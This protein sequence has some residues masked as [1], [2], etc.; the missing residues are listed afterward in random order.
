MSLSTAPSNARR[1]WALS[2][3]QMPVTI[4]YTLLLMI[5]WLYAIGFGSWYGF[6]DE[7]GHENSCYRR[8]RVHR[9]GSRTHSPGKWAFRHSS[10]QVSRWRHAIGPVLPIYRICAGLWRCARCTFARRA[11]AEGRLRDSAG[12]AGWRPDMQAGSDRR[13]DDEP[14]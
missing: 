14:R 11:C 3:V 6:A 9:F 8:W 4:S 12:C 13:D 2:L 7:G 1:Q 5:K 10:R